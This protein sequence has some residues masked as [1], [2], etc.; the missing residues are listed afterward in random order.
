MYSCADCCFCYDTSILIYSLSGISFQ[1]GHVP[2]RDQLFWRYV[3]ALN[4]LGYMDIARGKQVSGKI[5]KE[6]VEYGVAIWTDWNA[7]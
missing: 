6:L 7:L 1:P 4:R 5:F 3:R 2:N